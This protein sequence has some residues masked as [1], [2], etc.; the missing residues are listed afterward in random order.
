MGYFVRL[1]LDEKRKVYE[2]VVKT[3]KRNRAKARRHET[4]FQK[5]FIRKT[6]IQMPDSF[7]VADLQKAIEKIAHAAKTNVHA[8]EDRQMVMNTFEM[9]GA[10]DPTAFAQQLRLN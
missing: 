4:H 3:N 8:H 9:Q 1:A 10:L 7:S 6:R 5:E 2:S